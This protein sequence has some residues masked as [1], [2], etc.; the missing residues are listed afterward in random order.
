[1]RTAL[2]QGRG[3]P[4]PQTMGH[5]QNNPLVLEQGMSVEDAKALY[6]YGKGGGL[7]D[8]QQPVREFPNRRRS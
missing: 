8:G 3:T 6:K 1:M 7:V 4:F 2:S 5:Y